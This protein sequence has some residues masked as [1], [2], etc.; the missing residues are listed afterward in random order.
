M[1]KIIALLISQI[2]I[3]LIQ[4]LLVPI[5]I[6]IYPSDLHG[7]FV[8]ICT[9]TAI[10]TIAGMLMFTDKLRLWLNTIVIYAILVFIYHPNHLYGIGYG[11]FTNNSIQIVVLIFTVIVIQMVCWIFVKC[12]KLLKDF[13]RKIHN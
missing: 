7:N 12:L 3:Y 1:K 6:H 8:A 4:F 13:L 11:M 9:T 10:I 2:T 5:V